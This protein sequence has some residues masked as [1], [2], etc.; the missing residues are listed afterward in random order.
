M[1]SYAPFDEV[2]SIEYPNISGPVKEFPVYVH[3]F[4]EVRE[5][6]DP[7]R[8]FLYFYFNEDTRIDEKECPQGCWMIGKIIFFSLYKW[9]N[10]Y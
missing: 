10:Y 2:P 6:G 3:V 7:R 5:I 4:D 1:G 8:S 9:V